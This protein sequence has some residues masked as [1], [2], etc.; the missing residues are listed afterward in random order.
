[1]ARTVVDVTQLAHWSGKLTGIPRVMHELAVR[2]SGPNVVFAVWV[3]DLQEMCEIDLPRTLAQRGQGIAYLHEGETAGASSPAE[4]D[5][6]AGQKQ[7]RVSAAAALK[8]QAVRAAKAGLR[9]TAHVSPRLAAKLEARA[10]AA[11][12][13][14]FKRVDFQRGDILFIP[15]GEWWDERFTACLLRHQK[16]GVRLV[17]I[18]HDIGTTVWPQFF[19]PVKVNPSSYNAKIVPACT[20]VLT[21][22][23]NT[24]RELTAWLKENKLHVPRIEAFRLGDDLK[25]SRAVKPAEAR[26][27]ESGLKGGDYILCVG[28][29]EAKK[30]H[31][32]FYYVYKLAKARGIAL[33]KLVI[34]GR[35]GWHTEDI[36]DIMTRDPEVGQQFVFLHNASDEELSWL[37][38]HCLFTVLPSFH[39]GWGIPIAESVGRGVPCLCSNTSSMV[40]IAEGIVGHF[41]PASTDE[42]L[43]AIQKWLKPQELEKARARTKT[44]RPFTWDQSYKQIK[45][46]MENL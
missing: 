6:A 25:V 5:G 24:K 34:V 39:E 42:C 23:E 32:L 38:D 37:Y 2:F 1:M 30:N 13:R 12:L 40:E 26:F 22:S 7:N 20:L 19:E 16:A 43:A 27:K 28:T 21:V 15:W 17:Q 29:I 14:R 35:R 46:M 3:K 36:Y 8:K 18:I 31:A 9:R 33:P 44:Y 41:S 11:H 45:T 4:E 10:K